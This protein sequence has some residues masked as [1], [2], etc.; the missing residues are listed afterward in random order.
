MPWFLP[1]SES[2]KKTACRYLLQRY[3]GQFLEEKLTLDQLTVDLYNG[4]GTVSDVSLDVQALNELGEQQNFPVEFVDGYIS[5]ISVSIPWKSL[6]NESSYVEVKGLAF[7]VQPKQRADNGTSMF[8]SMW[9]SMTSSMQLAEEC[10][11]QGNSDE[12]EAEPLEGLELFAQTIDSILCKVKVKFI[13]T[14]IRLEHVPKDSS[15]GVALEVRIKSIDYLDEAGADPPKD[16]EAV[17]GET[18][19]AYHIAAFTTKK[20]CL[21]GVTIYTDEFPSQAR[22]FSRSVMSMS[23]GSTPDSKHS[24]T[25]FATAPASPSQSFAGGLSSSTA[26]NLSLEPD[27][28]LFGKLSGRHELRIKLKQGEGVVGPKVDLELNLG[29]LTIFSSPRQLHVL[30][31][32]MHGLSQ[33][34]TVDTSN[35]APRTRCSEKPMDPTDFQRVEQDLQQHVHG[36]ASLQSKG[37][38]NAQAWSSAPLDES[39]DEFLPMKN[40]HSNLSESIMSSAT[41]MDASISSSMSGATSSCS[42]KEMLGRLTGS[43]HRQSVSSN[44][45]KKKH[46][47]GSSLGGSDADPSAEVS[48]FQIRIG[49]LSVI[50]LHE[51]VLTLSVDL[52]GTSLARS[53]VYQMKTLANTFFDQLGLFSVSAMGGSQ[54]FFEAREVFL[55]AVQ[56]N[57]IR[58]LSSAIIL[59][60]RE[61]TTMHSSSLSGQVTSASME[62]LEC[63]IEKNSPSQNY[64]AEYVELLKF[65]Q[66]PNSEASASMPY[67]HRSHPDFRLNFLYTERLTGAP[68][69]KFAQPRTEIG[70][71]LEPCWSELDVSIVDRVTAVLNPQPMCSRVTSKGLNKDLWD[72]PRAS[73]LTDALDNRCQ[74]DGRVELKVSTASIIVKLRFPTPDLRPIHD[75]DRPPWWKRCVREDFL[76]LNFSEASFQT[77]FDSSDV[78][79]SYELQFKDVHGL[80]QEGDS[81]NPVTI[82]RAHADEKSGQS[83]P[84][85]GEGFG[86]PRVVVRCYPTQVP[87]DL[88]DSPPVLPEESISYSSIDLLKNAGYKEPS[89]F[90]SKRVVHESDTPHGK[91]SCPAQEGEE[92]VIPG[93]QKEIKDFIRYATQSSQLQF[94]IHIPCA[95]VQFPSKHMFELVYNRIST[96]LLLWTPSAPKPKSV[97]SAM[98]QDLSSFPNFSPYPGFSM[99][100]SGI[101]Y[102]SDSDS[103]EDGDEGGMYYSVYDSRPRQKS[104]RHNV[105]SGR[106][107][108]HFGQSQASV[109]IS[110]SQGSFSIFTPVRD[111]LGNVIPGQQGE[112][113]FQ[114][115]E[116]NMFL[117]SQYRGCPRLGYI[118]V[119]ANNAAVFHNGIA[120][121]PTSCP[122]LY[123]VGASPGAHL[124]PTMYRS[125]SGVLSATTNSSV[126]TG[127]RNSLDMVT[128]ALRIQIEEG[129]HNIKTFRV[130]VGVR[131]TTLHHKMST[132][133]HSWFKQLTD[134]FDILDYP[135]NGYD[136][137]FVIT[138]L[139]LHFWDCAIDY[140]PLYLP[141]KSMLTIGSLSISSNIAAQTKTSTLRFMAE[142]ACLLLAEKST[143]GSMSTIDLCRDYVCVLDL[144]LFELSL[145]LSDKTNGSGPRVDLRASNNIVH[146]RTCPDSARALTDLL[147]YFA[148]DGDLAQQTDC[149]SLGSSS[150][151]WGSE[152][153]SSSRTNSSSATVR[154]DTPASPAR[155]HSRGERE[156]LIQL[157]GADPSGQPAL[158]AKQVHHVHSLMEEAML[159]TN[160]HA[161]PAAAASPHSQKTNDAVEVFYFPDESQKAKAT[162][163]ADRAGEEGRNSVTLDH[164]EMNQAMLEEEEEIEDEWDED[165]CILEEETGSGIPP[166]SGLPEIR[167]LIP[168]PIHILENHFAVPHGKADLLKPPKHYPV[169]VMRYTLREMSVVWH[170]Y[171]GHDFGVPKGT[172]CVQTAKKRVHINEGIESGG[173]PLRSATRL[174]S[175]P[176]TEFGPGIV[177]FSKSNPQEVRFSGSN[178]SSSPPCKINVAPMTWQVKGGAGRNHDTLMELQLNKVRFQHEVYP[179]NTTEASRQVLL[180][181]EIEVRDRLASSEINK[182]LYQ[183]SSEARPKQSHANMLMLKAVH[184]RPDPK[185]TA[186]ECCL[187]VSLLPIRLNIDQD[188]L[189]FLYNF[190]SEI[191]GSPDDDEE[192]TQC[193]T[194]RLATP[195][196]Q[197]SHQPPV[198]TVNINDGQSI[199]LP[200]D[201]STL[202]IQLE[203]TDTLAG[204]R[205]GFS[206]QTSN[207]ETGNS[208]DSDNQSPAPPIY[209]RSFIF[210]PEVPIRLDY[211][212]KHVDMTH[213]PLAGL[214]MGLGQLN[215]S[216]LK[217]R[218]LH[219]RHGLLGFD[220]LMTYALLEWLQDIKKNQLPSLLGGVGPM[221]SLVQLFQGIRDLFWLPIE[222]YQKDGRIVRG[223]QRGANSFTTSTA[224]ATLELTSR[225]VQAIQCTAETA[226][227]MLSPGP[228]VRHRAIAG[229]G[230]GHRRKRNNQPLD[231]REG[232]HNAYNVVKEGISETAENVVRV[233]SEEHEQKGMT[234]AVGGVL[235]QIPGLAVKPVI[236]LSDATH[237]V[238]GGMRSQLKPDARRE[239]VEKWRSQD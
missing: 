24:D 32:L 78:C 160:G 155:S 4:T 139:H 68:S 89:P 131:G 136:K 148:G 175:N 142:D 198:M 2:L 180:I 36:L 154:D 211:H 53:S 140:R 57:H 13:D 134:F 189:L 188:S 90:S 163:F 66:S 79:S 98:A 7:T 194:P 121:V 170:M 102:E 129:S 161:V 195:T 76:L 18:G 200:T 83:L 49:S 103:I 82:L 42:G 55:Q 184:I 186:Q 20:F 144:G 59:E 35:V 54:A 50:L 158:S 132:A 220:K 28:I 221:H 39:D 106:E 171:G 91:A 201:Q 205:E 62:I 107:S 25:A 65:V 173:I 212:G 231:I 17:P 126:G 16:S 14:V 153:V 45:H 202:L 174:Q 8:E 236:F 75:M 157:E 124:F 70:I 203:E 219:H 34:D 135:V 151:P 164:P 147:A 237:N 199:I 226:Y 122:S 206:H 115:D 41:S 84:N 197:H 169:P 56:R 31:E 81:E 29:S 116:G 80:F 208:V 33:P 47:V 23:T 123:P 94:E 190:F 61:K 196:H 51:D 22:T 185:L 207:L 97:P 10:L 5:E 235:R 71:Q 60:G 232:M 63:L 213:G 224:M 112:F 209:F 74:S 88:D 69:R 120:P 6:L 67:I 215:C 146:I 12:K 178:V 181:Q 214:L 167:A 19:K 64:T 238:L 141:L 150:R 176:A 111:S 128:V 105:G 168:E 223:L 114:L 162:E 234:G 101:Q 15:S 73:S 217:L 127:S 230:K 172:P 187:R 145:R 87:G 166:K 233:A 46:K 21:E 113:L 92:L 99:C 72:C 48:H 152:S 183:Y 118:C 227:D 239:A 133:G 216:E 96:D 193:S 3:L 27:P 109:S 218:R 44:R 58:L 165:F 110:V 156:T 1:W 137:P 86:W 37:L 177:S 38:H 182:F 93:N 225:L 191:S 130:A 125:E 85:G 210:T 30:L 108:A 149:Q 100:K 52:D 11:K 95:T 159:D 228:S 192:G 117:V 119:Q 26:P 40:R 43:P 222:Q 104:A 229:K 179:E 138:E 77:A 204:L 143:N 9:S